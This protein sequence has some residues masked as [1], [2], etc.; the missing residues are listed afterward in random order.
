MA[1]QHDEADEQPRADST[2]GS[3]NASRWGKWIGP[4]LVL[5][6]I[7]ACSV[8]V[9]GQKEPSTKEPST[10][11]LSRTVTYEVYTS[12]SDGS[13]SADI[14]Q[15]GGYVSRAINTGRA[16]DQQ[17]DWKAAA[18]ATGLGYELDIVRGAEAAANGD[19][20]PIIRTVATEAGAELGKEANK[21]ADG[22]TAAA[23]TVAFPAESAAPPATDPA[24]PAPDPAT[25]VTESGAGTGN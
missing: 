24:A 23:G 8:L 7:G 12:D 6:G 4:L 20:L 5:A 15:V 25:T 17:D 11:D 21:A 14:T 18:T 22:S 1:E 2:P 10:V 13:R 3:R 9:S 16:I 19:P